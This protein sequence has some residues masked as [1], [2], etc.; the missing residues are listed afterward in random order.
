MVVAQLDVLKLAEAAGSDRHGQIPATIARRSR[1]PP[2]RQAW[3]LIDQAVPAALLRV[4]WARA[5]TVEGRVA[6]TILRRNSGALRAP[7][8]GRSFERDAQRIGIGDGEVELFET[9]DSPSAVFHQDDFVAR[10]FA[11]VLLG[12]V[13]EPDC[14]C[15]AFPS[16][17]TFSSAI[18]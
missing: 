14:E 9:D 13:C 5:K 12:S 16:W 15:L 2:P 1:T 3:R 17:N 7:S 6:C 4:Q 11:D 18:F 10:L 8:G